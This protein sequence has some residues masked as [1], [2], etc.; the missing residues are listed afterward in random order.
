MVDQ[1]LVQSGFDIE[2][3]LSERY[4]RYALLAQIEAGLFPLVV[5]IVD[6]TDPA[7]PI[8]VTI[9]IHPPTDYA[10]LYTPEPAAALP[11]AADGSFE[12]QLLFDDPDGANLQITVT[13]DVLDHVSGQGRDAV[14][15]GLLVTAS[16]TADVD[17]NGFESNHRLSISLVKLDPLTQLAVAFLGLDSAEVTAKIKAQVDRI[18]PFGVASGQSVQ[19]AVLSMHPPTVA[20]PAALGVYINL[21][22]KN[23]TGAADFVAAR[24]D[25][26]LAQSF[27]DEGRDLAFATSPAL[28]GML[29]TDTFLRMAEED[30]A[31]SGNFRHP[32]RKEPGN[33]ESEEIGTLKSI[34]IGPELGMDGGPTGRLKVDV[35]GEYTIEVLPDPTFHLLVF[36][37]PVVKDGLLRWESE[38]KIDVDLLGS[39]LAIVAIVAV[40]LLLGPG[41][42]FML[43]L[44]L[45]LADL[46]VDA[47]AT[48]FAADQA[49]SARDASF[50]DAL[51]HRMA[52][53]QRRWDPFYRTD[54]Q[55]VALIEAM[56]INL[57][58]IA[59]D[60]DA[61]LDKA[62][63][64]IAH[65]VVR[66]ETR[67]STGVIDGLH[68]RVRDLPSLASDLTAIAPGTD[69]LTWSIID[70]AADARREPNLVSLTLPQ[71]AE[72]IAAARITHPILYLPSKI[73][74]DHKTI[75]SMLLVSK[76]EQSEA[77]DSLIDAFRRLTDE[78][79]RANDGAAII[80]G[81]TDRLSQE[82]GRDP[83]AEEIADAVNA[84]VKQ[85]VDEAQKNYESDSLAADL[86]RAV[87]RILRF[88]ARPNE[89]AALQGAKI[90]A[91]AGKEI[92]HMSNG[93]VYYRDHPDFVFADNLLALPH[94]RLPYR[95]PP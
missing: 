70:R 82:L 25:E 33:P 48:A 43:F 80:D 86:T 89:I 16:L 53:A 41:T 91:V 8:N 66:D 24:G 92:I 88:D 64:A 61:V 42:G 47:I 85:R 51:P 55:V 57:Q 44:A 35:C 38:V 34:T 75:D 58:G 21:V 54:H 28:F 76:R 19:K 93:T 74:L 36:M 84:V 69:R 1:S 87:D 77:R 46:A 65:A 26:T 20:R 90:L 2:V 62:P 14:S 45:L 67:D 68:Y 52:V 27:L 5:D 79:I 94:Y 50:L 12:S 71:I 6:D 78:N 18:V 59:F 49:D 11:M 56:T 22:L 63:V 39:L 7:Q 29:G 15:I 30:P 17:D 10:R 40:G 83:T 72:R 9:T 3:L 32:L 4:V 13:A 95:P 81:E 31:G 60:G 23:G 73:H 37:K